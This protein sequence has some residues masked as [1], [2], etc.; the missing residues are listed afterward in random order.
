MLLSG[1]LCSSQA[2]CASALRLQLLLCAQLGLEAFGLG[3]ISCL[4]IAWLCPL[5]PTHVIQVLTAVVGVLP[6][7]SAPSHV[8]WHMW[9]YSFEISCEEQAAL[10]SQV[11]GFWVFCLIFL[12]PPL[13]MLYLWSLLLMILKEKHLPNQSTMKDNQL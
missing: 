8:G 4:L 5:C 10:Q 13:R 2:S 9:K 6:T 7:P 11:L 1:I 3:T 12:I